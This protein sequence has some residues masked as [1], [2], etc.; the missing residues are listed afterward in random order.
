MG[1]KMDY[2]TSFTLLVLVILAIFVVVNQLIFN[3]K[4]AKM[5][6][7]KKPITSVIDDKIKAKIR[8]DSKHEVV[9][10]E[11]TFEQFEIGFKS[12]LTYNYI[13][14]TKED[15]VL[16]IRYNKNDESKKYYLY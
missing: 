1:L 5:K 15:Y 9:E 11:G 16:G 12:W 13:E 10:W 6:N 4:M 7:N 3:K 14:L 8:F 2:T